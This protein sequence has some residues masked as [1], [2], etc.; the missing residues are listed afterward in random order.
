MQELMCLGGVE[1]SVG[2]MEGHFGL[3][4]EGPASDL[5]AQRFPHATGGMA[6]CDYLHQHL[7]TPANRQAFFDLVS[8]AGLVV[9]RNVATDHETYRKVRGKSSMAKLS[10]AEY[11]HHDGC[12]CPENPRVVEI[13]LPHQVHGRNVATAIA[14]FPCVLRAMLQALPEKLLND[15]EVGEFRSYLEATPFWHFQR[16]QYLAEAE[17]PARQAEW[18]K[19]QGKLTRTV[20]HN[21]DVESSRSYFRDVDQLAAAYVLPWQMGESRFMLNHHADLACTMQHRRAYQQPR[22]INEQN[23]SLVKRWPAEEL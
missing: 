4:I 7:L 16:K 10:Q 8:R 3:I 12:S 21:L 11:Y 20:R 9:C 2:Q 14:P 18:E 5:M 17:S 13:R 22:E 23:G 6:G 1:F 15:P 19:I